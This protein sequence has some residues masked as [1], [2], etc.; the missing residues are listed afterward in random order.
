MTWSQCASALLSLISGLLSIVSRRHEFLQF[1]THW[2]KPCVHT[3][4]PIPPIATWWRGSGWWVCFLYP[5]QIYKELMI[6]FCYPSW[7]IQVNKD[8]TPWPQ[9]IRIAVLPPSSSPAIRSLNF[10]FG[11]FVVLEMNNAPQ[12]V[13][14]AIGYESTA[15]Q[16]KQFWSDITGA[17][18]SCPYTSLPFPPIWLCKMRSQECTT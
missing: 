4:L 18:A 6:I 1:F 13:S 2:K 15:L 14:A 16:T 17:L 9:T 3:L 8:G 11:H 10:S 7:F 12:N 5:L